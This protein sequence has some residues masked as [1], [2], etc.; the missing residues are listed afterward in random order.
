MKGTNTKGAKIE[1]VC[2]HNYVLAGL[3]PYGRAETYKSELKKRKGQSKTYKR[4]PFLEQ[5]RY[6]REAEVWIT[7]S[8]CTKCDHVVRGNRAYRTTP[9]EWVLESKF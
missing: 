8:V 7:S 4:E 3:Q 2:E 6:F 1:F 9:T 5:T